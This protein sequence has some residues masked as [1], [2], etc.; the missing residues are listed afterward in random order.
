MLEEGCGHTGLQDRT[1]E[2]SDA[3]AHIRKEI[4]RVREGGR[5]EKEVLN[6]WDGSSLKR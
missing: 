4:A 1:P 2:P 6:Q 5:E 3:T